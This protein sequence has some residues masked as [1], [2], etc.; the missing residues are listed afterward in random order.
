M[1]LPLT[2][3]L[4]SRAGAFRRFAVGASVTTVV[5][6]IGLGGFVYYRNNS[7]HQLAIK[8]QLALEQHDPNRAIDFMN[9]ALAKNP[10]GDALVFDRNLMAKALIDAGREDDARVYLQQVLADKPDNSNALDMLAESHV[11]PALRKFK[12]AFKP[13]SV[14]AAIDIYA[15]IK[16][17]L[18]AF[19][20]LPPTPRDLVGQAELHHLYYMILNDQVHQ[21][22]S[23]LEHRANRPKRLRHHPGPATTCGHHGAR[24]RSPRPR[25]RTPPNRAETG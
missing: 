5:A 21:A 22:N 16:Q 2:G 4:P 7:P 11:N 24:R 19:A 14:P 23:A 10:T 3:E 9:R 17:E 13:I 8:A 1:A 6:A 15:T 12:Q 25:H 20:A 18:T